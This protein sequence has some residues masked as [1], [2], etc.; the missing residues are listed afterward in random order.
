MLPAAVV[1]CGGGARNSCTFEDAG[2]GTVRAVLDGRTFVLTDGREVRLAGIETPEASK[3]ALE[4]ILGNRDVTLKK[5]GDD[6]DRH[7]RLPAFAFVPGDQHSAQQF[8]L[9]VRASPRLGARRQRRL[10]QAVARR[11]TGGARRETRSLVGARACAAP[12]GRSGPVLGERGRFTLVEGKVLSVRE[13][14]GTIY[15]NFGRRWSEDFT[16]TLLKRNERAFT[17]AGLDLKKLS[18]RTV[19]LRGVIE[20]RGG[21]WLELTRPEQIEVIGGRSSG[22][23]AANRPENRHFALNNPDKTA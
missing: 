22:G 8:L 7:G 9:A 4:K 19:R 23:M 20:E 16:A 6:K 1:R 21:P 11:R 15:V 17:T 2:T 10:R 18:G 13:S 5:L 12:S 14:G 3:A